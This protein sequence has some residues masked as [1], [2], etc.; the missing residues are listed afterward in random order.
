MLCRLAGRCLPHF[1]HFTTVEQQIGCDLSDHGRHR[2]LC[3]PLHLHVAQRCLFRH[4]VDAEVFHFQTNEASVHFWS[5]RLFRSMQPSSSINQANHQHRLG[6]PFFAYSI[7]SWGLAGIVVT[8]G[9]ILDRY[10]NSLPDNII[11]P[12]FG[13]NACW[14]SS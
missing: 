7:Y 14:F 2:S 11:R 4:L 10:K 6:K 3:L 5:F 12:E 13:G 8:I 1:R 9:Q